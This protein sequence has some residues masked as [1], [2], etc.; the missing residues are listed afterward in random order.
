[1]DMLCNI[2]YVGFFVKRR[3]FKHDKTER[4]S[5]FF[6]SYNQSTGLKN[7]SYDKKRTHVILA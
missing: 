7:L 5:D 2:T 3:I 1:M 4:I 6:V